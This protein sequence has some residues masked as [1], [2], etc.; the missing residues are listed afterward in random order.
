MHRLLGIILPITA[1]FSGV[2]RA[3]CEKPYTGEQLAQDLGATS[4]AL[5]SKDDASLEAAGKRLDA[6]L[7]CLDAAL[8]P[9]VFAAAYR[10]VGL[11]HFRFGNKERANAWFRSGLEL[12]SSFEWDIAEVDPG[13]SLRQ[14]FDSLRGD[15]ENDPAVVEGQELVVPEGASLV[16]DGRPLGSAAATTARP[17]ILQLVSATDNSVSQTFLIE[18]NAIPERFLQAVVVADA[19]DEKK[20]RRDKSSTYTPTDD[21]SVVKVKRVRPAAKTPLMVS[22]AVLALGAGGIYGASYMTRGQFDAATTSAELSKYRSLT[23]T[24]VVASAATLA[25][26]LSVEYAGIMLGA[27]PGGA[28]VGWGTR[29]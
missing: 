4:A 19:A 6:G 1:A 2:A 18:G 26:G 12:D 22:G 20:S 8:P 5:R 25:V 27:T 9:T 28:R 7:G 13:A 21:L 29:F 3:A 24:L 17:H 14:V 10:S 16:L 11:Y 23:N 15:A